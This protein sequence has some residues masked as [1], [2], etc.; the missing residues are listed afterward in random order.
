MQY[1]RK[2]QRAVKNRFGIALDMEVNV[3]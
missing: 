3:W 2:I 1:A